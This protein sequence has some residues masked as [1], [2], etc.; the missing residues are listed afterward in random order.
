MRESEAKCNLS[1]KLSV[2]NQG[3]TDYFSGSIYS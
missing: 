2:P 3:N 1:K